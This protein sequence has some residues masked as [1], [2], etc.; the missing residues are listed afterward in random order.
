MVRALAE[1]DGKDP[2]MD[3]TVEF[4]DSIFEDT[5]T[6]IKRN[7]ELVSSGLKS[8]QAAIM[9][10]D[11]CDEKEAEARLK[12]IASEQVVQPETVDDLLAG[13]RA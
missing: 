5:G 12:Q 13:E 3:V 8:K 10:I 2:C 1:L 11:H 9:E 7:I 6:I 4:D